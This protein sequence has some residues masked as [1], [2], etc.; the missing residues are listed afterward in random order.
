M[1]S[2]F[3][4]NTKEIAYKRTERNVLHLI[5]L[6]LRILYPWP[7][8]HPYSPH[9]G[10]EHLNNAMLCVWA[11]M[12][13]SV[14]PSLLFSHMSVTWPYCSSNKVKSM[15]LFQWPFGWML[16]ISFAQISSCTEHVP[17]LTQSQSLL[18]LKVYFRSLAWGNDL[19]SDF[20]LDMCHVECGNNKIF[21]EWINFSEL[22][23]EE[24]KSLWELVLEQFDDLLVKILLLAAIISFV[25]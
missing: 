19:K 24:G 18:S 22:P 6:S 12:S 20:A 9:M 15:T 14:Y 17:Y 13:A 2:L 10:H 8:D 1:I 16:I 4:V 11:C 5:S 25:R 3:I 7:V 21:N 23:A